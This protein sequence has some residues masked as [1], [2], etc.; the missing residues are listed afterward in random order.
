MGGGPWS[1]S[2]HP[3]R[4]ARAWPR[5]MAGLLA[6][7]SLRCAAFPVAQWRQW[8]AAHRSQLRGQPRHQPLPKRRRR[9][10]R[11]PFWSPKG[12]IGDDHA[13]RDGRGS[14]SWMEQ[15]VLL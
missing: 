1:P 2:V 14:S 15:R 3:A 12:T 11:V 7:G 4:R 13:G 5:S 9:P 10:H 6:C 8:R